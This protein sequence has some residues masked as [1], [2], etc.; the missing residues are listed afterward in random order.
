[1]ALAIYRKGMHS[2]MFERMVFQGESTEELFREIRK[3][4]ELFMLSVDY[5]KAG[6]YPA[7]TIAGLSEDLGV[8]DAALLLSG[9]PRLTRKVQMLIVNTKVPEECL[10]TTIAECIVSDEKLRIN[11]GKP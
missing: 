2:Y 3:K 11:K 10:Y 1:M 9:L 6:K 4:R 8:L 5:I 7:F